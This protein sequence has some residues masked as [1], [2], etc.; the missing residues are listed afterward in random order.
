MQRKSLKS[1]ESLEETYLDGRK[2]VASA[3][4][5]VDDRPT[6]RCNSL[7]TQKLTIK[8]CLQRKIFEQKLRS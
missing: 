2:M 5:E 6:V 4:K 1:M 8:F 3:K 7:S